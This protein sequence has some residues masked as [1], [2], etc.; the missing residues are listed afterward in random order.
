MTFLHFPSH[1]LPPFR[2]IFTYCSMHPTAGVRVSDDCSQVW[3]AWGVAGAEVDSG[4]PLY[5]HEDYMTMVL[6]D[7]GLMMAADS[8]DNSDTN[9]DPRMIAFFD[10]LVQ[11]R[12][13]QELF[14]F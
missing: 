9:E 10:Y 7:G 1:P 4:R 5:S 11:V 14:F 8:T 3:S 13:R 12:D 6:R 2:G